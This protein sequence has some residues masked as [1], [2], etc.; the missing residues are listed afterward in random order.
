MDRTLRL[1]AR[2]RLTDYW[3]RT[4]LWI[5]EG[6]FVVKDLPGRSARLIFA[7]LDR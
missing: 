3:T 5:H 4:D 1:S 2:S 7:Q 6:D